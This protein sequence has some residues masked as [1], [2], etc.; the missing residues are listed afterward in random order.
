MFQQVVGENDE[1]SH[2]GREREFFRF[3]TGE[4]P[5]VEWSENRVVTGGDESGHVND[6]AELRA[7]AE[8]VALTAKLTTVAV[9]RSDA[10]EGGGL[11][12][13]EGTKFGA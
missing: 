7:A 1:P 4:A 12:S 6:R 2:E 13:G 5:E 11:A 8:D 3:A 10:R 9:K